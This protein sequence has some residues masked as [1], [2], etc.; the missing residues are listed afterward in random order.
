MIWKNRSNQTLSPNL[1]LL[2]RLPPAFLYYQL[3]YD[4]N[5]IKGWQSSNKATTNGRHQWSQPQPDFKRDVEA[6]TVCIA[7]FHP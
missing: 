4:G 7:T 2:P 3:I 6:K 1:T 5:R